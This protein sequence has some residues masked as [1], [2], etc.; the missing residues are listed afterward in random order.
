MLR[1]AIA[2]DHPD[3]RAG[4]ARKLGFF[5]D[6]AVVAS[7]EDG[8]ELLAALALLPSQPDV[9]LMDLGMPRLDGIAATAAVRRRWPGVAV[10][11]L[12]VFD[13]DDRVL[14]ALEAGAAGYL[15]KE[16]PV[17]AVV[18]A[19]RDAAAGRVPLS[20]G[21]AG[22]VVRRSLAAVRD[23]R[24]RAAEAEALGLTPRERDVL[25]LLARG[26]TDDGAAYALGVSVHTVQTHKKALFQKLGVHSRAEA[27]RRAA[28]LGL[29]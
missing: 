22:A 5:D 27:A 13:D 4:L 20:P 29:A 3:L 10:V 14:R 24:A 16:A 19:V 23:E 21:V 1:V 2:E 12:T 25:R 15:L 9:V 17:R 28:E 11:A 7:A 26:D 6:L 8:D 18:A